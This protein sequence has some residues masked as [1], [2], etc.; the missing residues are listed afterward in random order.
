[1]RKEQKLQKQ[2]NK[3]HIKKEA[4]VTERSKRAT[5]QNKQQSIATHSTNNCKANIKNIKK[6]SDNIKH[7]KK[8]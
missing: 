4:T 2:P 8:K 6:Q 3:K 1:M 7:I 5:R